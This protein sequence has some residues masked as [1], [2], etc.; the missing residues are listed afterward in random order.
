MPSKIFFISPSTIVF[1]LNI[2]PHLLLVGMSKNCGIKITNSV[3]PD[4][5]PRSAASDLGLHCLLN[6]LKKFPYF[7][8]IV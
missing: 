3:D 5:T 7:V 8:Q 4:Q 6:V 1:T 2:G